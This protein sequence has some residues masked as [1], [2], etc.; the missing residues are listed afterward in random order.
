MA[1][2]ERFEKPETP[3]VEPAG[4]GGSAENRSVPAS[5]KAADALAQIATGS[6]ADQFGGSALLL[7]DIRTTFMLLNAL[8]HRVIEE[9]F[10]LPREQDNLLT[11]V[12]LV[13]L[14][15]A[16]AGGTRRLRNV[17]G[18][19]F[20]DGMLAA[21][22]LGEVLS[23]VAGP[24]SRKTPM[25]GTIL[26]LAVAGGAAGPAVLKSLRGVRT[27]SHRAS[28]DFHDRYGYLIDP[29]HWRQR[30]AQRRDSRATAERAAP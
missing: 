10:G 24:S 5:S 6:R 23:S 3:V 29:G 21:G 22:A 13:M 25:A 14:A 18:P 11:L 15:D 7:G 19:A 27:S 12:A 30:R 26:T 16:V 4:G 20:G 2:N 9:V 28:V 17:R 8:R 1:L